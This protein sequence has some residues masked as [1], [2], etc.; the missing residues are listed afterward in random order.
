MD[1]GRNWFTKFNNAEHN[2]KSSSILTIDIV[3]H[4][5]SNSLPTT[6]QCKFSLLHCTNNLKRIMRVLP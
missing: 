1:Q 2:L 5:R 6:I 4:S 3:K